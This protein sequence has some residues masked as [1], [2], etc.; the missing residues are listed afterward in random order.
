MVRANLL[1]TE[2]VQTVED[3]IGQGHTMTITFK[4]YSD[5]QGEMHI[6]CK[7]EG[8][9]KLDR[10]GNPQGIIYED[11]GRDSF[12]ETLVAMNQNLAIIARKQ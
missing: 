8:L 3:L 11:T 10:D 6:D 4:T 7:V 5:Y 12:A 9:T 2:A 1:L